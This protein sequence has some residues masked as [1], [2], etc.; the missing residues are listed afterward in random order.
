MEGPGAACWTRHRRGGG[1]GSQPQR[2]AGKM[3]GWGGGLLPEDDPG[4][5]ASFQVRPVEPK[6]IQGAGRERG[7]PTQSEHAR[8]RSPEPRR[9]QSRPSCPRRPLRRSAGREGGRL[10]VLSG[11]P[12]L[13]SSQLCVKPMGRHRGYCSFVRFFFLGRGGRGALGESSMSHTLCFAPAQNQGS[14]GRLQNAWKGSEV[15]CCHP[16]SAPRKASPLPHNLERCWPRIPRSE[17]GLQ[18]ADLLPEGWRGRGGPGLRLL[19]PSLPVSFPSRQASP[20]T[21]PCRPGADALS[22]G[23]RARACPPR[24]FFLDAEAQEARK[25][26]RWEGWAGLP[27]AGA[28]ARESRGALSRARSSSARRRPP[29]APSCPRPAAAF[30]PP[31][32]AATTKGLG[33][34]AGGGIASE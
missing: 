6:R 27:R 26:R 12:P 1:A 14:P 19:L 4:F 5:S 28:G 34:G 31:P 9:L 21:R 29:R 30:A 24:G 8:P 20:Q 18:A 22:P 16:L 2:R 10:P 3:G 32:A 33:W 23:V 17:L 25:G 11:G 13:L 15:L 7:S